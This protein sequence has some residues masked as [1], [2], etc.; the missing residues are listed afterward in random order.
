MMVTINS[1]WSLFIL[2]EQSVNFII[3]IYFKLS[4]KV[5]VYTLQKCVHGK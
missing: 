4:N 1:R 3:Q 2:Y 5:S